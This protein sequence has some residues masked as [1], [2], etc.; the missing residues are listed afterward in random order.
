VT[1]AGW[2]DNAAVWVSAGSV[3]RVWSSATGRAVDPEAGGGSVV[4]CPGS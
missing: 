2:V 1:V 4:G 3:V